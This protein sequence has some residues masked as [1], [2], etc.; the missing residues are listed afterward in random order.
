M[1]LSKHLSLSLTER[2]HRESTIFIRTG[3]HKRGAKSKER[4]DVSD[5]GR[6]REAT[7]GKL[8]PQRGG[9]VDARHKIDVFTDER[10]PSC[11]TTTNE[12]AALINIAVL[13]ALFHLP[14]I[15]WKESPRPG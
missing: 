15:N 7:G 10:D 4:G 5:G 6:G 9:P 1:N 2:K 14:K 12:I 3:V 13:Q 8:L 11:V